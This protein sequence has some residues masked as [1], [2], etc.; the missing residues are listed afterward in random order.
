ME[1]MERRMERMLREARSGSGDTGENSP[2]VYGW[3]MNIGPE[4]KPRIRRFGN[5]EETAEA[6][7]EEWR[8]PF[9]TSLVDD[10]KNLVRFTAELPGVQKDTID[11]RT[12]EHGLKLE[13]QGEE[14]K[15]RTEIPVDVDLDPESSQARYNNGILEIT[16]A[17]ADAEHDEG[18]TVDVR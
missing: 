8:E 18:H 6:G 13:A 10:D 16:V 5:V 11:V 7:E 3:T 4:G 9:V 15:Y 14:R 12:F 2:L 1:D 17:L